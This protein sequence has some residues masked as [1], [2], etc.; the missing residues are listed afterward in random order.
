VVVIPLECRSSKAGADGVVMDRSAVGAAFE[1][2]SFFS[3]LTKAVVVD[4]ESL[5]V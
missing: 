1:V 5:D 2:D 4:G 3:V